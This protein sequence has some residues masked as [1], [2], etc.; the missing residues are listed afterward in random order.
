METNKSLPESY[1]HIVKM[2]SGTLKLSA[3]T[4]KREALLNG[5]SMHKA[6]V[7]G[8]GR[9]LTPEEAQGFRELVNPVLASFSGMAA[10]LEPDHKEVGSHKKSNTKRNR[11]RKN[12]APTGVK[13]STPGQSDLT[14]QGQATAE[15]EGIDSSEKHANCSNPHKGDWTDQRG[16]FYKRNAADLTADGKK[17][18]L[19]YWRSLKG[20]EEKSILLE[21]VKG[22][23]Y[24]QLYPWAA[25][26]EQYG[27]CFVYER[28]IC[29]HKGP[30]CFDTVVHELAHQWCHDTLGDWRLAAQS[31][32]EAAT[33]LISGFATG[34]CHL[35]LWLKQEVTTKGPSPLL[36]LLSRENSVD[37]LLPPVPY[38]DP[39]DFISGT[40]K[41]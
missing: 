13:D 21:F 30:N 17:T 7:H 27:T 9:D 4:Y 29:V 35:L 31:D 11:K 39:A 34:M 19:E 36:Q 22:P 6:S 3:G 18:S 37:H 20:L 26:P 12:A 1:V 33:D 15:K 10:M 14:S 41:I 2:S 16:R 24:V 25:D 5:E 23:V 32:A 28:V 8:G 38:S 40:R